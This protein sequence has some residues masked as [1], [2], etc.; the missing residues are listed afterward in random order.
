[1]KNE[2]EPD[3]EL[4]LR[5]EL[6]TIGHMKGSPEE[7][8]PIGAMQTIPATNVRRNQAAASAPR[9]VDTA[10]AALGTQFTIV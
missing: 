3:A 7:L 6:F 10:G 4:W 8:C 1:M 2:Q 5:A 9:A